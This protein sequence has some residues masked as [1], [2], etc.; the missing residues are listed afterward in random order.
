M[1]SQMYVSQIS[2]VAE[3]RRPRAVGLELWSE[4]GQSSPQAQCETWSMDPR[5]LVGW[6]RKNT[7][8][9]VEEAVPEH[10]VRC[11]RQVPE[12]GRGV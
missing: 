5:A 8:L 11:G 1:T 6:S 9:V 3:E 7:G 12:R 2:H 4:S 10:S